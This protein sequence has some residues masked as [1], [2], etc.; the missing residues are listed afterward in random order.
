MLRG[1]WERIGLDF[2]PNE[3]PDAGAGAEQERAVIGFSQTSDSHARPR[4]RMEF[5]RARFPAP[6]SVPQSY[7]EIALAVLINTANSVNKTA[8]LSIALDAALVNRAQLRRGRKPVPANPYRA[9]T[10]LQHGSANEL[11]GKLRVLG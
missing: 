7:P 1:I 2:R 10:V 6:E 4:R 9:L 3:S 8:A 5:R 11:S